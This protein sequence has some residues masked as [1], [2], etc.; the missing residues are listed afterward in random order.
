MSKIHLI[1]TCT[2]SKKLFGSPPVQLRDF[3][4]KD[5]GIDET[6]YLWAQALTASMKN[7][8]TIAAKD[9]YKGAHW[10]IAK[11]IAEEFGAELWVLSAGFGLIH[12]DT[13]IVN[14]QAT[15]ASVTDD[16]IPKSGGSLYVRSNYW[17]TALAENLGK[18]RE[19]KDL[20]VLMRKNPNDYFVISGSSYYIHAIHDDLLKGLHYLKN[21]HK[22]LIIITSHSNSLKELA[23]FTLVSQQKM[24]Q[25]LGGTMVTLNIA[26]AKLFLSKS[27]ST[28]SSIIDFSTTKHA[29]ECDL[30][31]LP[32]EI[33]PERKRRSPEE[34]KHYIIDLLK[35]KPDTSASQGLRYFRD[36]GNSLEEKSFRRIFEEV[37][38]TSKT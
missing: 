18:Y 37:K 24:R 12:K 5:E 26:L 16:C 1:T 14:Y 23:P 36:S 15:F 34:V 4:A 17:W 38:L 22:Q 19:Y 11:S 6:A 7:N 9:L 13:K 27:C 30:K 3:I 31:K 25:L 8:P 10:H 21:P 29:L 32:P 28:M 20:S 35:K 33:K 2:N